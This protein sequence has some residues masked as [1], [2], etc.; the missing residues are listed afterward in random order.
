MRKTIAK[1]FFK[2]SENALHQ[3]LD[4]EAQEE[5]TMRLFNDHKRR[6]E[7]AQEAHDKYI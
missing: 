4:T 5:T 6:W 1:R 2:T 3:A 7:I